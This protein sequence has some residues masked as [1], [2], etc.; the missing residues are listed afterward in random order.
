VS[1][2]RKHTEKIVIETQIHAQIECDI[3]TDKKEKCHESM[4]S[5]TLSIKARDQ[6]NFVNVDG[7]D[8][9]KRQ[10]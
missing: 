1:A 5:H 9:L 4:I 7:S 3:C 8:L 2:N 6:V 10:C